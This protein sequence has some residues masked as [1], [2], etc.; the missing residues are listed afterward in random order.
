MQIFRISSSE[1]SN[2]VKLSKFS[3]T[4]NEIFYITKETSEINKDSLREASYQGT[5]YQV[6]YP[7]LSG[8]DQDMLEQLHKSAQTQIQAILTE[9]RESSTP[10][11]AE[12]EVVHPPQEEN[13]L[14]RETREKPTTA[15]SDNTSPA[16]R[17][18][19]LRTIALLVVTT[20]LTVLLAQVGL[21]Y[22]GAPCL[23]LRNL[24]KFYKEYQEALKAEKAELENTQEECILD[25]AKSDV[26]NYQ[27]FTASNAAAPSTVS[28]IGVAN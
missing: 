27:D 22:I 5:K 11:T 7:E 2:E 15:V 13:N 20:A 4:N 3:T 8:D 12:K 16:L 6:Y 28:T 26:T 18:F 19:I 25:K 17:Q 14:Q 21:I 24:L 9:Q 1:P 23:L 10:T